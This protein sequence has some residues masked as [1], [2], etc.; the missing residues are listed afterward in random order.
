MLLNPC[1]HFI[2]ES[3][4]KIIIVMFIYSFWDN[5]VHNFYRMVEKEQYY[6]KYVDKDLE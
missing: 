5:T 3:K 1:K 4:Q 6:E 2:V